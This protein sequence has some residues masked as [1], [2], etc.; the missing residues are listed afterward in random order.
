[1]RRLLPLA[2]FLSIGCATSSL[3]PRYPGP[4]PLPEK[5]KAEYSYERYSGVK[6]QL[7]EAG[8][9]DLKRIVLESEH[10][11]VMDFYDQKKES[12]VIMVLPIL[13]GDNTFANIFAGYFAKKGF[14]SVIVHRQE[15][16]KDV[17]NIGSLDEVLRSMVKDHKQAIDWIDE[18]PYLRDIGVFGISMGSIKAALV[19]ALDERISASMM[20]LTG[21]DLPYILTNSKEKGVVERT[22][23]YMKKN[24]ITQDELYAELKEEITCDPVSYAKY[25]DAGNSMMVLGCF[26]RCVPYESGRKLREEMGGPETITLPTGHMS[27]ILYLPYVR[28]KAKNFFEDRLGD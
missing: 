21:G 16:Y 28:W 13:G 27:A 20:C 9:Y 14:S 15:K 3:N 8:E 26:D 12:D 10:D 18:Q 17:D 6:E 7:V 11:I 4:Q 5:I 2:L 1:M 23:E 19:S 24:R 22:E 25:M